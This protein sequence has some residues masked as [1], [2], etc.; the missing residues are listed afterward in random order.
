MKT[1]DIKS[2]RNNAFENVQVTF[3]NTDYRVI[4]EVKNNLYILKKKKPKLLHQKKSLTL[5]PKYTCFN[6]LKKKALKKTLWKKVKLLK[7]SNFTFF[8]QCFL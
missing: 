3:I 1:T 4:H 6:A 8:P 2:S 5:S 7:M